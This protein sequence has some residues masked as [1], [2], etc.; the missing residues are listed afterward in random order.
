MLFLKGSEH[1][2]DISLYGRVLDYKVLVV[3]EHSL[4]DVSLLLH[5]QCQECLEEIAINNL[6]LIELGPLVYDY[7]TVEL[8]LDN[9][10]INRRAH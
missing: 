2:S 8:S 7:L 4:K 1:V 10:R 5:V 9:L 3:V 6:R